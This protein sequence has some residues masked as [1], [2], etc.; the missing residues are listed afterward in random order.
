MDR[1]KFQFTQSIVPE[2]VILD[3]YQTVGVSGAITSANLPIWVSSLVRNSTGNY[4]L[5]MTDLVP[6]FAFI[7]MECLSNAD[8]TDV[9]IAKVVSY[10]LGG[11]SGG[12]TTLPTIVFQVTS[13]GSAADIENGGGLMLTVHVHNSASL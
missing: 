3:G 4:T 5:T 13:G 12:A 2:L 6:S 7:H 11:V 9:T 8:P 1:Y 10:S